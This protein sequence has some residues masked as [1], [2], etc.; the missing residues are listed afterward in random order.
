MNRTLMA[1]QDVMF[2]DND[3]FKCYTSR[4]AMGHAM[5]YPSLA[6]LVKSCRRGN[7]DGRQM[8]RFNPEN[9][10]WAG[11]GGIGNWD[12]FERMIKTPWEEGIKYTNDFLH[13]FRKAY[14]KPPLDRRRRIRMNEEEGE[15]DLPR[16]LGGESAMF[17][18]PFRTLVHAPLH[19]TLLSCV[20]GSAAVSAKTLARRSGAAVALIDILEENG[21]TVEVWA[22]DDG[23]RTYEPPFDKQFTAIRLKE[24]GQELDKNTIINGLSPWVFRYGILNSY[25]DCPT[26]RVRCRRA[27]CW[28]NFAVWQKFLNIREDCHVFNLPVTYT[29]EEAV[30]AVHKM[31]GLLETATGPIQDESI[32]RQ[33]GGNY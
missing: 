27:A 14:I 16:A 23:Q 19:V 7:D 6:N 25:A 32:Y 13:E 22:W 10:D 18:N 28:Y 12:D 11:I 8:V 4:E 29:V 30:E 31:L 20:T 3:L 5:I 17:R 24:A 9:Y 26:Q 2:T 15:I 21:Y 33:G 1:D